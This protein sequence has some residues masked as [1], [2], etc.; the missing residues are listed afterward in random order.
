[1]SRS[2]L[3]LLSLFCGAII[4]VVLTWTAFSIDNK[5]LSRALL[6]QDTI[7]VY[8]IGPGPLLGHDVQRNPTY[9]GTPIH[10]IILPVGFLLSIPIYSAVSYLVLRASFRLHPDRSL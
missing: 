7:L 5:K 2:K 4:T 8:L 9:E 1:M 3:V 10:M 6:W